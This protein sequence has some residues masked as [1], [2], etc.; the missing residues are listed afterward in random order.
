MFLKEVGNIFEVIGPAEFDKVREPLFRQLAKFIASPHYQVAECALC[1]WNS[2]YFRNLVSDNVEIILPIMFASL[3]ET[4]KGHWNRY[5]GPLLLAGLLLTGLRTIHG[6]VYSVMAS[7]MDISPQL[8]DDC[9]RQY[10]KQQDGAAMREAIRERKW[11][12]LCSKANQRRASAIVAD[13]PMQRHTECPSPVDK[14]YHA[15]G[16]SQ[17]RLDSLRLQDGT[18][19]RSSVHEQQT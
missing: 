15:I 7:F 19:R 17:T 10:T 3:C 4:Y 14:A 2:E 16:D 11:A 9:L 18:G 8:F 13:V 6:M 1:F 12:I 5:N